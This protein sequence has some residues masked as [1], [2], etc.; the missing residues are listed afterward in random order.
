MDQTFSQLLEKATQRLADEQIVTADLDARLLLQAASGY[1]RAQYLSHEF[2]VCPSTI[3]SLYETYISRRILHEP[4]YRILGVREFHGLKFKL[5]K[6]TL[7]PRDDTECLIEA[8][9]ARITD[10]NAD[11]RFLDLG[12]GTGIIALS[13]LSELSKAEADAT[14][15]SAGAL[16]VAQENSSA[17]GFR[18]RIRFQK[19]SWL[20]AAS[21][22]YDFIVSNPPYIDQ[23]MM[24]HLEAEVLNHDPSAALDGGLRGLEAFEEIFKTATGF[25]KQDGFLA[26]EIGFDQLRSVTDLGE[27][28]GWHRLSFHRDL[29]GQ[30][31]S[32]IFNPSA[33]G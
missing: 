11:L 31:R 30:M 4:V 1:E 27:G 12:T 5:G 13:L 22:Q 8:V 23:D 33:Y 14:D 20:E 24:E 19:G 6:D 29:S 16:K 18:D 7:E 2:A 10:K 28:Y 17:L 9:V 32:V 15:I 25:L 21:G 3:A 26:L